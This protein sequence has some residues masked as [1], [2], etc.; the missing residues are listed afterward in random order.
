[1][2][3]NQLFSEATASPMRMRPSFA[4]RF[5]RA[6]KDDSF[7]VSYLNEILLPGVR[8]PE[9]GAGLFATG[10]DRLVDEGAVIGLAAIEGEPAAGMYMT[11]D[12]DGIVWFRGVRV[13]ASYRGLGLASQLVREACAFA[14]EKF[15]R[16]QAALTVRCDS[17]GR[18]RPD[19][20]RTYQ[21]CGFGFVKVM[22]VPIEGSPFD[23]HLGPTG[24]TFLA[25]LMERPL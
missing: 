5:Q 7:T 3:I 9:D 10:E 20:F 15:Q 14:R 23:R 18:P 4:A 16:Q 24:S 25:A 12:N 8:H 21:R 19:P 1:M 13:P 11:V 2:L 17:E 22:E 6:A